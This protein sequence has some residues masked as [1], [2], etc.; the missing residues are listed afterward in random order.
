MVVCADGVGSHDSTVEPE[1]VA[2][3]AFPESLWG[4]RRATPQAVP[5]CQVEVGRLLTGLGGSVF[6][7]RRSSCGAQ[8]V[9]D[10]G[11]DG[12]AFAGCVVALTQA[13]SGYLGRDG[14]C[15]QVLEGRR[16]AVHLGLAAVELF[17]QVNMF[18]RQYPSF[19]ARFGGELQ[20]GECSGRAGGPAVEQGQPVRRDPEPADPIRPSCVASAFSELRPSKIDRAS[21]RRGCGGT[22]RG[23]CSPP[24]PGTVPFSL[25]PWSASQSPPLVRSAV[26][27]PENEFCAVGRAT[28][29]GVQAQT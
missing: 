7:E 11:V 6:L 25:M 27:R 13:L 22:V 4:G 1:T 29:V 3:Q 12:N 18:V 24:L 16:D 28:T 23:W 8:F 10:L 2:G 20:G 19:D 5:P 17:F 26:T 15:V 9:D 14:A 21:S